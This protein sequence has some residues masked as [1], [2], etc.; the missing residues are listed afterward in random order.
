MVAVQKNSRR[1]DEI[2]CAQGW[3][4]LFDVGN[5]I[6]HV[7]PAQIGCYFGC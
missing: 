7:L 4:A 2:I 3:E 6:R 5:S 1:R